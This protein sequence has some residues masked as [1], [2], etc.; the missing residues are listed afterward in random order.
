VARKEYPFSPAHIKKRL[1]FANGYGNWSEA[2]W[3]TI[4]FGDET[5]I[6]LGQHGQVWVQRPLGRAFDSEYMGHKEPH[7]DRVSLWGCFSGRGLGEIEIF[8]DNLDGRLMKAILQ[9]HLLPSTLPLFP[10]EEWWFLQDNDPKHKS[11]QV[12][13]WLH[14]NGVL[15]IDFPP[16]S[17]DLNPIE[18]LWSHL[19]RR[20]E[21]RNAADI[22]ELKVHLTQEWEATDKSL[23]VKLSH[24]MPRRC[25]A[26]VAKHGHK[27]KY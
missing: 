23:L 13:D 25:K 24:S 27:T 17:P 20:V 6:E 22:N 10:N 18:N 4:M 15:C 2:K 9:A 19:K 1:S 21:K 11:K 5:H 8:T 16:Y 3:D 7:P 12:K 26:V 14:D